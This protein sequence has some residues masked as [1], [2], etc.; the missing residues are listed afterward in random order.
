MAIIRWLTKKGAV[1]GT[2][3]WAAN[4]Y[5]RV[6]AQHP[7]VSVEQVVEVLIRMR[8]QS[9]SNPNIEVRVRSLVEVSPGL[10]GLVYS[11]LVVEAS[12][13]EN[14]ASV[15]NMFNEVII[16]ELMN[17]GVPFTFLARQQPKA[18]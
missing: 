13:N 4:G 2:A 3:R 11:I 1:G 6:I 15:Q 16:E 7:D 10:A 17:A 5:H 8:Y 12:F 14:T 18:A 9:A